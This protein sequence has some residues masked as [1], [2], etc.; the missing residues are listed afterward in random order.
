M[1][2][3]KKYP[4]QK[5]LCLL[6]TY[7]DGKIYWKV[8]KAYWSKIG[9]E[10]GRPN[11]QGRYRVCI[12]GKEYL[13]SRVVYIMHFGEIPTGLLIDHKNQ[14]KGDDRIENLR[15]ATNSQNKINCGVRADNT[16]GFRG[17]KWKKANKKWEVHI[18]VNGKNKY[19]GLFENKI[20]A[21]AAYQKES[22]THF[23]EFSFT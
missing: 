5:E 23:K 11:K 6:F 9:D 7:K 19:I 18:F 21:Y 1:K 3:I 17:V 12:D 15:L 20:D 14:I 16:S 4:T 8:K 22:K 2:T 10:A 13:R